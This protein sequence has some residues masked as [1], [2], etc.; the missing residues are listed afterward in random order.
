MK[1]HFIH[2]IAFSVVVWCASC[3]RQEAPPDAGSHTLQP[4]QLSSQAEMVLIPGGAYKPFYGSDTAM[5][6]VKPFLIDE[7]PVTNGEFL[8]FVKAN[9]QWQRSQVKRLYADTNYLHNWVGDTILPKGI[10]KDAPV[11]QLSWY[12]AKAYAMAVGKRLPLLDEWELV[13]MADETVAN[14]RQKKSYSDRIVNLYLVKNRQ[15]NAVKQS[16]P[17]YWGVYNLFDLVWEWTDDFNSVLVT[18]DA[19]SGDYSDNNL[20]CA[21]SA[22]SATDVLNYAAFMRFSMRAGLKAHYTVGNLGFRCAKDAD[23]QSLLTAPKK[24]DLLRAED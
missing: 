15:Y 16:P 3:N 8:E 23:E 20:F 11:T 22:T 13:A 9:P 7:R 6:K 1:I 21:G 19:R 12:A 14:A 2:I 4:E 18:G 17:N 24:R 5:V 10:N